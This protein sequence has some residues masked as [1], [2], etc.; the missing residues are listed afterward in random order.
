MSKLNSAMSKPAVLWIVLVLIAA[1]TAASADM[2]SGSEKKQEY[3][4]S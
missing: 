3:K 2:P 4:E 1:P